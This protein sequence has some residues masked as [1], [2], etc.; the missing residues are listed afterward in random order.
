MEFVEATTKTGGNGGVPAAA[1]CMSSSPAAAVSSP[2]SANP[3]FEDKYECFENLGAGAQGTVYRCQHRE[4]QDYFAVKI[5]EL[6]PLRLANRYNPTS[7]YRE[8]ENQ[9]NLEHPNIV[10]L[11]ESFV[12]ENQIYMVQ[13]YCLGKE[14]FDVIVTL[15]NNNKRLAENQ[16]K[17]AFAQIFRAVYYLHCHNIV[18]RDIKPANIIVLNNRDD[19]GN[20]LVKLLDFGLSKYTNESSAKTILG[21]PGYIAPEVGMKDSKGELIEY[22]YT[23][24]C[25]SLGI[26]LYNVLAA[27]E[28]EFKKDSTTRQWVLQ[29]PS[30]VCDRMS[31]EVKDLI[32]RLIDPNPVSRMTAQGSLNHV[33]LH[34]F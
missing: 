23:A 34:G 12:S 5:I 3:T 33:W 29:F 10:K 4:T 20:I 25:Y 24:D 19:K 22:G 17:T 11:Y 32:N 1:A 7:L 15:A 2:T 18:H 21:T 8:I 13:E 6:A 26:T 27:S 31:E 14:L 16:V 9:S 30:P 28:P